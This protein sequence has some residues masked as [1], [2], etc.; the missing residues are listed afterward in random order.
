MKKYQKM[1]TLF[2]KDIAFMIRAMM[3]K[4]PEELK[5]I[6][7]ERRY[8]MLHEIAAARVHITSTI[9]WI[10]AIVISLVSVVGVV[11]LIYHLTIPG[12]INSC[13]YF[14]SLFVAIALMYHFLP[15]KMY[16]HFKMILS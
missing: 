7:R 16:T 12:L 1:M 4:T 11:Y 3:A 2:I 13:I 14:I 5:T 10:L 9:G 8:H 6:L 15:R